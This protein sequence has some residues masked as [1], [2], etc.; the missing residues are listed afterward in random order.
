M[1]IA[2]DQA[3]RGV[4]LTSPNPPVGAVIVAQGKIIG[5]GY[6][7]KAGG[8]HAEI[9]A[10]KAA[11]IDHPKLLP[12]A[13]LFV[14]LEPCCTRGRTNPCTDA[15]KSCGIKRVVWGAQDPNPKHLGRAQEILTAAGISVTTGVLGDECR[16]MIRPFAKW[17]TTGLPYVIAKVGQSL[18]GRITRPAG[19][20]Q[21]ITSSA[22]RAHSL[23][24]RSRVDAIIVG[25]ET[26]RQD[27]PLLTLRGGG[28]S[29]KEQP[30]RVILTRS[31]DLPKTAH[32]FTDEFKARTL[33]LRD[34]DFPQVLQELGSR[35]IVSVLVEGGA[36]VM[37]QA[38]RNRAVDEAVWY[39]APLICG[40]GVASVGGTGLPHSVEL[41]QVTILPIGDN[42]CITGHPVWHDA[43]PSHP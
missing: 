21:W 7:R 13:A 4:G 35:G 18:D 9:E 1:H 27:N 25:A 37:G 2:L 12:G 15:I 10:I 8:P 6:H 20:G 28:Q 23:R 36:D 29:G 5:Q 16:E 38:F 31:G 30:L 24:L 22:A 43:Q 14:T 32:V 41:Q 19:E 11:K 42:V 40:S 39:I 34:L 33:V 26:I 17:I 3:K